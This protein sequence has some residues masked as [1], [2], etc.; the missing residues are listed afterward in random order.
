MTSRI[1]WLYT[2][3]VVGAAAALVTLSMPRDL[4]ARFWA[5][6]IV[7]QLL[8]LVCDS[9]P[10]LMAARQSSWSPSTAALSSPACSS[11]EAGSG[12]FVSP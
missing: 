7:L 2:A 1:A 6:L 12:G 5:A 4:P 3:L 10:A 11:H 8:F 9:T